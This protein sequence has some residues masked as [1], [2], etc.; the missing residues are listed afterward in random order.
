MSAAWILLPIFID[1]KIAADPA[2]PGLTEETLTITTTA[3]FGGWVVGSLFL[4]HLMSAFDKAQLI[5]AGCVGLL[6]VALATATLPHLTA[7]NLAVFTAVRFVQGLL[8]NI[9]FLETVYVQEAVPPGWGNAALVSANVGF[10]LVDI[11]QAFLCGGPML[12]LDWRLQV[13]LSQSVPLLLALLIGFPKRWEILCSLPAASKALWKKEEV[14]A[15]STSLTAKDTQTSLSFELMS[16]VGE[17]KTD[18]II[19]HHACWPLVSP[20]VSHSL[21]RLL[22]K[23]PPGPP[24]PLGMAPWDGTGQ[25]FPC[26]LQRL[27][28]SELFS[29]TA[30][31]QQ[32]TWLSIGGFASRVWS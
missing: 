5:V 10:C 4:Q 19:F 14:S 20:L 8:Q 24:G 23:R 26:E 13:F 9:V 6:M 28:G 31:P 25:R 1:H 18:F 27:L 15:E 11:L 32:V 22:M 17:E 2:L 12:L 29:W 30:L 3:I 21:L 7:G 16:L